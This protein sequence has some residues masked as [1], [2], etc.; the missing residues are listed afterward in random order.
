[1][2]KLEDYEKVELGDFYAE[3]RLD[4]SVS[5]TLSAY[6]ARGK[7]VIDLKDSDRE[8]FYRIC[9]PE[10]EPATD[11]NNL[12]FGVGVGIGIVGMAVLWVVCSFV[13]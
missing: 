13:F 12:S 2:R 1:M 10:D 5:F 7:E 9:E 6:V 11:T 4:D 8:A 3:M